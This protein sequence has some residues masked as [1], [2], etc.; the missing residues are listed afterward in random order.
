MKLY[1][2]IWD[3]DGTILP[4]TPYDSEHVLLRY[5]MKRSKK[6]VSFFKRMMTRAVIFADMKEW[7]GASFKKY[8]ILILKGTRIEFLD[9][10]AQ[11]LAP[12][13]SHADREAFSKLKKDGHHMMI[14]SCG[15][16]DLIEPTLRLAEIHGCFNRIYG[17]RFR[18]LNDRIIGMN[19]S[20]LNPRRQIEI[21][22][23][24]RHISGAN[25]GGRI[26]LY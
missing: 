25:G 9:R 5:K 23:G 6:G 4:S 11:N 26:R 7:L 16:I 13:I 18:F 3:F 1:T 2:I 8:Y 10:V 22:G 19:L 20:L 21:S 12:R 17:N 24:S 15:T 14:L